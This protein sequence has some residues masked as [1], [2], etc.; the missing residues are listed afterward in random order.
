MAP[1]SSSGRASPA[2]A[3][4]AGRGAGRRCATGPRRRGTGPARTRPVDAI[5]AKA[6][7]LAALA[8]LGV[9][10]ESVQV[11]AEA[12]AWYHPGR[13]GSLRQGRAVLA[14]FGELHPARPRSVRPRGAG[15]GVRARSRCGAAAEGARPARPARHWSRCPSRRSTAT[16]PSWSME[17]CRP[18]TLLDAIRSVDRRLVREVRLFDVYA[19][20]GVPAGQK[21]L[22]VA[23]RLQAPDRTLTEAEIDAVAG[24][25]VAAA[26]KATG[27]VLRSD[28]CLRR[29]E[30]L[31][32]LKWRGDRDAHDVGQGCQEPL[33]RA[34]AGGAEGAGDHREEWPAGGGAA[35]RSRN[36]SQIET[37]EARVV[38]VR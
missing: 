4:R 36:T 6:D 22:A 18:A 15:R 10:P 21:S 12:P 1:C 16:S 20:P 32:W 13:S 24:R 17:R 14:T 37:D 3:G 33:R 2:H 9:K 31:L 26:Q 23:V 11:A 34:A 5:D 19:G 29:A 27:A 38:A 28:G 8:V 35:T 30:W 25:I 7:A